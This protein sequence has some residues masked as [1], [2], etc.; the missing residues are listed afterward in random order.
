VRSRV[1]RS[2][3][4]ERAVEVVRV[5][6]EHPDGV[7]LVEIGRETGTPLSTLMPI[8][9]SLEDRAIIRQLPDRAYALDVGVLQLSLPYTEGIGF[10]SRFR[11]VAS[12][13]VRTF[14]ETVQ[15]G[16]LAGAE[17]V[18]VAREESSEPVRLASRIGRRV[19]AHASAAGKALLS[20]LEPRTVRRILGPEPLPKLTPQTLT[21]YLD[22]ERELDHVRATGV[23]EAN[24]ECTPGLQCLASCINGSPGSQALSIVISTPTFRMTASKRARMA[25]RIAT[26]AE[27]ISSSA[28]E[29]SEI[30]A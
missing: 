13:I 18:Y 10:G 7:R 9:G 12:D 15:L 8:L 3:A 24:E 19:P 17:V 16:V 23:A 30:G 26:A 29:V 28:G 1:Y 27:E 2:R 11:E 25:T 14:N 6:G 5:I 20:A 22:L 4:V 21:R